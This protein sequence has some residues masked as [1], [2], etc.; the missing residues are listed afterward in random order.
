MLVCHRKLKYFFL[1]FCG[2]IML[3]RQIFI[4]ISKTNICF[5]CSLLPVAAQIAY[6]FFLCVHLLL[7]DWST[8]E[9]DIE[10]LDGLSGTII[11]QA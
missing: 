11:H 3:K 4:I 10:D 7:Q 9:I 8:F 1:R 6:I 2:L 5:H